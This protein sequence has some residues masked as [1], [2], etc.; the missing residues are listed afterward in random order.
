MSDI[1]ILHDFYSIPE[2]TN[3][4]LRLYTPDAYHCEPD[5]RFPVLYM[6]DGQNIF[7]HPESALFHTWC[8]NST[9]D[10]LIGEGRTCPWIIVAIDHL[11]DRFTEYVPWYEPSVGKGG[12]GW[13]FA[14]FLVNHLKPFID[15]TY[16]TLPEPHWTS[17][18]GA[19]LGGL[20]S[21][22]LGKTHPRVFGRIG[23]VSPTVMWAGGEIFRLWD[24]PTGQWCKIYMDTGS[25][26]RY[27]YY[28][29]YLDFVEATERFYRHLK[30]LGL[31][32][33]ELRY[34]VAPDHFHDEQAWQARLPEI[35]PWLLEEPRGILADAPAGTDSE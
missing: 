22:V 28:D 21:L 12:R 10:R 9:M 20:M 14:D 16:R 23:A 2:T 29:L 30:G 8:A 6:L 25:L 31:G 33:H 1:R 24:S 19:S 11:E 26:E 32:D 7:S 3:R 18:L 15:Q 27:W 17:V 34:V 5:R 4:T 13:Q 35:L